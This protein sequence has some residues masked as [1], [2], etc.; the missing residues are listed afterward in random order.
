LLID[1]ESQMVDMV[2]MRLEANGYEVISANDG[3]EGLE[4]A[5]SEKPDLII[6]DVMMPKMDGYQ[7]CTILKHD[8]QYNKIPISR[9]EFHGLAR[10]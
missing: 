10:G 9:F 4:K 6:L 1:D 5:K 2:Q 7:V 8:A 3:E